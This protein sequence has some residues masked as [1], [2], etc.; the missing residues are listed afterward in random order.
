MMYLSLRSQKT[1]DMRA[2]W[3]PFQQFVSI[4]QGAFCYNNKNPVE[5]N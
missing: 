3:L 4:S 5:L 2:T 1:H